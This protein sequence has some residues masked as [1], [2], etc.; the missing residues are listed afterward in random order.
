MI[1]V[2]AAEKSVTEPTI[3]STPLSN[4]LPSQPAASAVE[5]TFAGRFSAHEPVY[6]IYG[7]DAPGAKFQFSFKYRLLG[8]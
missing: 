2:K 5:R 1:E 7:P 4:I 3:V 6:F 8:R